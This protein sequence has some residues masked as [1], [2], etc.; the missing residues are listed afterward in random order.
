M[1]ALYCLW[2]KCFAVM[3]RFVRS[4]GSGYSPFLLFCTRIQATDMIVLK[5]ADPFFIRTLVRHYGTHSACI[6]QSGKSNLV[7]FCIIRSKDGFPGRFH[8]YLFC[9]GEK[10]ITVCD[11]FF[12]MDPLTGKNSLIRIKAL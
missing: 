10:L 9:L 2:Q 8:H 12:H 5:E 7:K 3:Q 4:T 1:P 6:A 11:A